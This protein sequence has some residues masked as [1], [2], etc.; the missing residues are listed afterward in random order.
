MGT[1]W[2]ATILRRLGFPVL[3]DIRNYISTVVM[4]GEATFTVTD[5][6]QRMIEEETGDLLRTLQPESP[7]KP[8]SQFWK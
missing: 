4:S 6:L 7:K 1:H 2:R 5:P 3:L 8:W